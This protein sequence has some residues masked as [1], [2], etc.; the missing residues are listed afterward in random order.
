MKTCNKMNVWNSTGQRLGC[1]VVTAGRI[2]DHVAS[3]VAN[4]AANQPLTVFV[5]TIESIARY[6][7]DGAATLTCY[8]SGLRKKNDGHCMQQKEYLRY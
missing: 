7:K 3:D 5:H 2:P 6:V 8:G 4:V 1:I